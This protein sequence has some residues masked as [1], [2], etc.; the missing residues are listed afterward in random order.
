MF[1]SDFNARG[2]SWGNTITNQ[3]GEALED[4]LD[5]CDLMCVNDG[6]MTRMAMRPGDSD[7]AIDLAIT[8]LGVSAIC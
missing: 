3:Q 4:A 8:T 2:E 1:S 7:S 5:H 6:S